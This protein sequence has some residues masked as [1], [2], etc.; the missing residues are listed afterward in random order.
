MTEFNPKRI[1]APTYGDLLDP[2]MEITDQADA[3]Q[4]LQKYVEH[5]QRDLDKNPGKEN[6][7][8]MRIAK[9]NLGYYSSYCS[10]EIR[11][12]VGELFGLT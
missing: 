7:S 9:A 6:M 2:A 12:R 5:I 10:P 8:A 11:K 4:Y 3:H 1:V